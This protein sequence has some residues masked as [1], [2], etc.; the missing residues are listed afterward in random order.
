MVA[1]AQTSEARIR[2]RARVFLV[3]RALLV[4]P[5]STNALPIPVGT[6]PLAMTRLTS[7][8]VLVVLATPA[9][10]VKPK[11]TNAP[12]ILVGMALPV[13]TV[14]PHFRARVPSVSPDP[15]VK[16][17]LTSAPPTLAKMGPLAAIF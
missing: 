10:F 6:G 14:S 3:I 15:F 5:T 16:P 17:T 9:L 13:P 1:Y 7:S 4:K 8:L 12:P 11:S 2:F